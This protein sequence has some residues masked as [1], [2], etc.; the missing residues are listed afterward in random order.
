M[1]S[2]EA[3]ISSRIM[4]NSHAYVVHEIGLS[5]INGDYPIAAVLPGDVEL[6]DKY[7]VSR[8]VIREAMKTLGAKGLIVARS[9]VGTKVCE[10]E[11]WNLLDYD[12][13]A[14]HF[15]AGVDE[16]FLRSL[17]EVRLSF[18]PYATQLAAKNA[19]A[20]D[21]TQLYQLCAQ[22]VEDQ[23]TREQ[24]VAIDVKFHL[25]VLKTSKNP[26]MHSVG[27]MLEAAITGILT[28]GSLKDN[29]DKVLRNAKAH[30]AVVAAIE[31]RDTTRAQ[32][33]MTHI[34][35]LDLERIMGDEKSS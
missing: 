8:T 21:I 16:P 10:F 30:L 11:N 25:Y 22:M 4:R 6:M 3:I 19:S 29:D 23:V 15:E 35:E 7:S 1:G 13:L 20:E 33:A 26:I 17:S 9:K 2:M 5:I 28:I 12:V 34:I 27:S 32:S 24:R 14:W 18:E 31:E